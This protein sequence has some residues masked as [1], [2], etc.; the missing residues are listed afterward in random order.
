M[1]AVKL[2]DSERNYLRMLLLRSPGAVRN[3]DL[4]T[5]NRIVLSSFQQTC[6]K[7]GFLESDHHWHDTTTDASQVEMPSQLRK[8]FV[9]I[10][11][12]GEVDVSSLWEQFKDVLCEDLVHRFSSETGP[13]Y[14]LAEINQLLNFYGL[15][16]KKINPL[17]GSVFFL[18]RFEKRATAEP[19]S[20]LK[21]SSSQQKIFPKAQQIK[22]LPPSE[23]WTVSNPLGGGTNRKNPKPQ[24]AFGDLTCRVT[25]LHFMSSTALF[26]H[27]ASVHDKN[28][29]R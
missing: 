18:K 10:F 1:P 5:V 20:I 27:I 4:K 9:V 3:D 14:A 7:L 25:K 19:L 15:S 16:L 21:V 6:T 12:F 29:H 28:K 23:L 13:Q 2:Q 8:R 17:S 11:A 22:S 26:L 24:E